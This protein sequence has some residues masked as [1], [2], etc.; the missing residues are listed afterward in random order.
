[1]KLI[2]EGCAFSYDEAERMVT[3]VDQI[4]LCADQTNGGL[5]PSYGTI[6]QAKKLNTK[7]MVM[8]R[9]SQSDDYTATQNE[10]NGM[11]EDIKVCNDLKVEG[12]VFGLL[13]ADHQIDE[14]KLKQLVIAS[15]KMEKIFH[16][17][18]DLVDDYQSAID[19]LVKYKF[20]RILTS[21]GQGKAIN[22]LN[23]LKEI[24]AYAK[25]KIQII[26]GGG[27]SLENYEKIAEATDI[28][29]FHG[30]KIF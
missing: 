2:R 29:M 7:L 20:T 24:Q 3:K 9:N 1:M 19:L 30:T 13:T 21:G 23:H 17:A 15:G 16:R 26:A 10:L 4:E 6:V 22:N 12:V 28:T 27:V 5:T 14:S 8:I 25:N 18:F 11:L